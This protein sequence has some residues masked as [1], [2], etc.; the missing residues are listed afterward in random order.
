MTIES[1]GTIAKEFFFKFVKGYKTFD[2]ITYVI[3]P[4]T[5][6]KIISGGVLIELDPETKEPKVS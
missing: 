5:K 3:N 2:N 4:I 1:N 6:D